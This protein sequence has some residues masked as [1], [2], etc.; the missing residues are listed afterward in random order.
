M[1]LTIYR[2][3]RNFQKTHEPKG[4]VKN[5][6]STKFVIQYHE[7]RTKHY[8]LRLEYHGILLSWAVPKGLS[9]KLNEKR[10]AIHVEDH[11]LDYAKFEGV[12]PQGN[13]GAGTVEIFDYGDYIPLADF[14]QG[15]KKG[16]L[17]FFLNGNKLKGAWSLIKFQDKHWFVL[18]INDEY[19]NVKTLKTKKTLPFKSTSVQLA[20]FAHQLPTGHDWLFEIKYDGYRI[21]SYVENHKVKML[22]R[23]NQDYTMKLSAVATSLQ[24]ME[25]TS[26]VLDGEV[27]CFDE[28]GKSDFGLLQSSIKTNNNNLY[29]CVFDLLALDGVD[30]R[31]QPLSTRK[32]KLERLLAKAD[33]SIIYSAHTTQGKKTLA[34]AQAHQLEGIIAKHKDSFYTGKKTD[35]WLKIKCYCRQEFVIA[36]YTTSSK[37]EILATLILGYFQGNKLIYVGKVGT[38]FTEQNKKELVKLFQKAI[39]SESPFNRL[40]KS[41]NVVWLKPKFVAEIQFTELTKDHILRQPS[42][43]GLR[44]D[45]NA[46]EVV[47]EQ[48]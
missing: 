44:N 11:P 13:Y 26:M 3:K 37:N 42:F 25:H 17:K 33:A 19:A 9:T 36:G 20:T 8:D 15:L 23:N 7:A 40:I 4:K 41:K 34:F 14:E 32:L 5:R 45:K 10:L 21:L 43:I 27:V 12:I 24:K 29:Y 6:R 30:L 46:N 2:N 48:V 35:D 47:W 22:T 38:G 31:N 18:K 1:S 16:H 28:H 39:T